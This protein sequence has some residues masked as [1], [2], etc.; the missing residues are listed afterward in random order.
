[1]ASVSSAQQL[2]FP[3]ADSAVATPAERLA[4]VAR[5]ARDCR[6]CPLWE[7]GTQ[8][9]FGE[10]ATPAELMLIGE[11]PGRQEDLQGRPFVGPSG[12]LLDAALGQAGIERR[13]VYISNVVKHRPWQQEGRRQKNRPPRAGEV[14]ACR[15]WLEAELRLVRPRLIVCLGAHA[16]RAILG[17][18]FRLTRQRGEW[19]D[20]AGEASA[21]ATYHPSYVLIQPEATREP[22]EAELFADFRTVASRLEGSARR[23]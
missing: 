13:S 4:A 15:P 18:A 3:T 6:A 14:K 16:A 11:A 23:S 22:L 20:L 8:T 21:L 19:L 7:I 5:E 10:G 2:A 9:V 12:Q 1:M 17:Q